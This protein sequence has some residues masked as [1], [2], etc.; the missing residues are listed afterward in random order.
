MLS[1]WILKPIPQKET[2][3]LY[4]KPHPKL[5][6]GSHGESAGGL[7]TLFCYPDVFRLSGVCNICVYLRRLLLLLFYPQSWKETSLLSGWWLLKICKWPDCLRQLNGCCWCPVLSREWRKESDIVSPVPRVREHCRRA[8]G[9]NP[10]DSKRVPCCKAIASKLK[11]P[12]RR[13]SRVRKSM[14]FREVLR[15][16]S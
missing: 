3:D 8:D 7:L 6:L 15:L 5:V 4:Y 11:H 2:H 10:R 1:E 13:G 12:S 9:K 14:R 16:D